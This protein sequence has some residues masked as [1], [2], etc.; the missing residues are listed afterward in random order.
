MPA[1][2]LALCLLYEGAILF[3][4]WNDRR[5]ARRNEAAEFACL[6]DTEASPAPPCR[7]RNGPVSEIEPP[8]PVRAAARS[9]RAGGGRG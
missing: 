6:A 3:A 5:R 8:E 1:L 2:A 9:V 4:K 7:P